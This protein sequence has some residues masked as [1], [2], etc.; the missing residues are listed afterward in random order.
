MFFFEF[1]NTKQYA[2]GGIITNKNW[3]VIGIT[4]QGKKFKK[5]IT[6]GRLSDETDVKNAIKKMQNNDFRVMEVTSIKELET[7]EDGGGVS[8]LKIGSVIKAEGFTMLKGL[9]GGNYYTVVDID[10]YSATLV[11]SDKNGNKKGFKRVRH[12]LS[13]IEG[14]IKT[15]SRGDN[16]G[17]E[18]IKYAKGGEI[19]SDNYKKYGDEN[20]K[21][22]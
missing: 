11:K 22:I 8:D 5:V 3:E 2:K 18:V 4:M 10:G 12:Y 16:N 15:L 1:N 14:G 17:F 20:S 9:D 21:F 7:Y 13:S 6:L 19:K